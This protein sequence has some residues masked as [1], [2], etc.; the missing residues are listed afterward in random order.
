M[1]I[2]LKKNHILM[3]KVI[4]SIYLN[5]QIDLFMNIFTL[6]FDFKQIQYSCH[7]FLFFLLQGRRP[8]SSCHNFWPTA[9]ITFDLVPTFLSAAFV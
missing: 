5:Q 8:Y 7:I 3:F 1:F 9:D 2:D 6:I 4:K